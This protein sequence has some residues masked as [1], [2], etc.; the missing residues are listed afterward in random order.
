MDNRTEKIIK[1][2]LENN[3]ITPDKASWEKLTVLLDEGPLTTKV[4]PVKY[5]FM[6]KRAAV[7]AIVLI[8][9]GYGGYHF[10]GNEK[11]ESTF[12]ESI[13]KENVSQKSLVLENNK[14]T[15]VK[16]E[17]IQNIKHEQ[18]TSSEKP[19][20]SPKGSVEKRELVEVTDINSSTKVLSAI[21]PE[22]KITIDAQE[23]LNQEINRFLVS[24]VSPKMTTALVEEVRK[25]DLAQ[26]MDE[27]N[28]Q[29]PELE[30]QF[31]KKVVKKLNT[32]YAQISERNIIKE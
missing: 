31:R 19:K 6:L 8:F 23:I 32:I 7:A 26:I 1:S 20:L 5:Y 22:I 4:T 24:S 28:D 12:A 25:L 18:I 9:L 10:F 15:K 29:D 13:K 17:P 3:K 2:K 27:L 16:D 14:D 11:S 30:S 21:K